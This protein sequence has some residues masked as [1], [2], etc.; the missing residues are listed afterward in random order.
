MKIKLIDAVEAHAAM[1]AIKEGNELPILIAWA[2]GEWFVELAP[3]A[4]R[5][6][7]QHEALAKKFGK[8]DPKN[9]TQVIIDPVKIPAFTV[10]RDKLNA[11]EVEVEEKPKLKLAELSACEVKVPPVPNLSALRLFIQ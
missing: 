6:N 4:M 9:P 8:T 10:E 3:V 7:E 1:V 2:L 5:Y 11:I